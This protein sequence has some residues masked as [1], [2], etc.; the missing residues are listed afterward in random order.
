MD[1]EKREL[2]RVIDYKKTFDTEHGKRVLH[3]LIR[4]Y[5]LNTGADVNT[6]MFNE[7]AK[8]VIVT[9]MSHVNIDEGRLMDII[10]EGQKDER[11]RDSF[12]RYSGEWD[13]LTD[14]V[15]GV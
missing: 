15:P 5:L 4:R 6:A 1:Q 7:G 3:D 14:G 11:N 12:S 10:K 9:I 2:A 8:H 13:G